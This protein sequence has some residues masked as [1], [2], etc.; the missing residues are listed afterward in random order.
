M[1]IKPNLSYATIQNAQAIDLVVAYQNRATGGLFLKQVWTPLFL[2][3][4]LRYVYVIPCCDPNVF[5]C[6]EKRTNRS[7]Y[8]LKEG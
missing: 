4:N 7:H 8:K 2:E 5:V 6:T 3:D 1:E